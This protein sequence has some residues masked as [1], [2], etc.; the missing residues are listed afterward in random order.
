MALATGL[1]LR[2]LMCERMNGDD[3]YFDSFEMVFFP[4]NSP[5]YITSTIYDVPLVVFPLPKNWAI[6]HPS[7]GLVMVSAQTAPV[8]AAGVP[9]YYRFNGIKSGISTALLQG[10]VGDMASG[11]DM[12]FANT[13][14]PIGLP[15]S[16]IRLNFYPPQFN[17]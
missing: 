16:L 6:Y 13:S 4:G 3:G 7:L 5:P 17:N 1:M 12:K 8:T 11:A 10:T 2:T 9:A 14:W 15:V